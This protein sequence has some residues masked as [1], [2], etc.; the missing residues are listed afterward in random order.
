VK[1]IIESD[2]PLAYLI[3]SPVVMDERLRIAS[4]SQ[5]A[6]ISPGLPG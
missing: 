3:T 2:L 1:L 5:V 4:L 6:P